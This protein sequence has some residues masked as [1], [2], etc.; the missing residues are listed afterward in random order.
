MYASFE[1]SLRALTESADPVDV[2]AAAAFGRLGAPDGPD[3][4]VAAAAQL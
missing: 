1:T 4:S 2:D 3:L